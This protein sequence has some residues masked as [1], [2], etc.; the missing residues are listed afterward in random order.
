MC[1][2]ETGLYD[3]AVFLQRETVEHT[4]LIRKEN[5]G[6]EADH[7]NEMNRPE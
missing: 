4:Q 6:T 3:H 2:S 5:F 1:P 7:G